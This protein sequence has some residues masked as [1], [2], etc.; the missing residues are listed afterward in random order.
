MVLQMP[1]PCEVWS[2]AAGHMALKFCTG[3]WIHHGQFISRLFGTQKWQCSSV[4][5][6]QPPGHP[7]AHDEDNGPATRLAQGL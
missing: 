7:A 3:Q 6:L 5:H 4:A 1:E 2:R